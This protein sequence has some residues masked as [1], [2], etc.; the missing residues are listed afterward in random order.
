MDVSTL[1]ELAVLSLYAQAI[2][3]PYM[4]EV[5]GPGTEEVNMLDLGPLHQKVQKH[6]EAIIANLEILLSTH[7]TYNSGSMNGK[8][9]YTPEA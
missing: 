4:R 5:R 8:L 1:T 3:D 2:S 7:G 9:L 6:M